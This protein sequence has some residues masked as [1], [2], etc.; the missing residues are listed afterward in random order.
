MSNFKDFDPSGWA[1]KNGQFIGLPFTAEQAQVILLPVP[2]EATVSYSAGT[3]RGPEAIR[4]ASYQ[5]DL[6][7]YDLEDAWKIGLHLLPSNPEILAKSDLARELATS[8]IEA[9]EAGQP[10]GKPQAQT[11]VNRLCEELQTW[12]YEQSNYWLNQGKS[13]GLVGGDHSTPLGYLRALAERYNDFGVLHIDAH[14]DLRQAYEGFTYSHASIFYNA[15]QELPSLNKLFQVGIRDYCQEEL[16]LAQTSQGR[17]EIL[18]DHELK[19]RVYQGETLAKI[20][21]QVIDKLPQNVYIS[22]DIDALDPKLCPGTGTPV[23]GGLELQE[24][25][26]LCNLLV[27]SGRKIIGFDLNEV[28]TSEWDGNVGARVLYKLSNLMAKSQKLS[29]LF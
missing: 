28:G 4:E 21:G 22:F 27:N 26:F 13:L 5:L 9:L 7:D 18:F 14:A 19:R 11:E 25:F 2:W 29:P 23:A 10:Q 8:H 20:Y 17:V 3:A 15:V 6:Y 16:D 1:V 24:A 12:V